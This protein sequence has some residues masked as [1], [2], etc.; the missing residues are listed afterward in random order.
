MSKRNK[1][2]KDMSQKDLTQLSKNN[3]GKS[4][5]QDTELSTTPKTDIPVDKKKRTPLSAEKPD[6]KRSFIEQAEEN[7]TDMEPSYSESGDTNGGNDENYSDTKGRN[8]HHLY[9]VE[10]ATKVQL[11]PELQELHRLLNIDLSVKLDQK[12]DPLQSSVN[13]IKSHL[14]VQE[15]KIEHVMK[16]KQE[17][18]KL[19]AKCSS[20]EKENVL[21]KKRITAIEN[22]LLENNIILQGINEDAWEL[23]SVLK[24]ETIHALANTIHA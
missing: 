2:K 9:P 10:G 21:L 4:D 11:T 23:N 1:F 17:N 18:V 14:H 7:D 19:Q 6:K 8:G 5:S 12:L 3:M 22:H 15:S 13:E 16:I 20:I 24:V